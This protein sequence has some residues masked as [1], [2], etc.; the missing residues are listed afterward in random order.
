[1]RNWNLTFL[2]YF[3]NH[4]KSNL[5]YYL[6]QGLQVVERIKER[7]EKG[8]MI[9]GPCLCSCNS[10]ANTDSPDPINLILK[11]PLSAPF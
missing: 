4:K 6:M 3:Q 5:V 10:S 2:N 7:D 9:E 11:E 1:M 8:Q